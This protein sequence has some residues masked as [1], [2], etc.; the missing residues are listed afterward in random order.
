MIRYACLAVS[1]WTFAVRAEGV[2]VWQYSD[3]VD[4]VLSAEPLP[5]GNYLIANSNAFYELVPSP[6]SG[7][8]QINRLEDN[9]TT[10]FRLENGNTLAAYTFPDQRVQ[11]VTPAN[12]IAWEW[13]GGVPACNDSTPGNIVQLSQLS[14]GDVL[15]S[16]EN[17]H[18]VMR[19]TRA[20]T[21]AWQFGRGDCLTDTV[22]N[23]GLFKPNGV[24]EHPTNGNLLIAEQRMVFEITPV[25]ATG[26]TMVR[27]YGDG[28]NVGAADNQVAGATDVAVLP[29]GHWMIVDSKNRRLV[30]VIPSDGTTTGSVVWQYGVT[31]VPSAAPNFLHTPTTVRLLPNG[32]FLVIDTGVPNVME[33]SRLFLDVAPSP[34]LEVGQCSSALGVQVRDSASGAQVAPFDV[35]V[36]LSPSDPALELFTDASCS[37]PLTAPV[38]FTAGVGSTTLY[39]KASAEGAFA[40]NASASGYVTDQQSISAALTPPPGPGGG[41]GGPTG[42]LGDALNSRDL[43]VGCACQSIPASALSFWSIP[44]LLAAS[45]RRRRR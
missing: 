31:G 18:R 15:L 43:S 16:D 45:R 25:G 17:E 37:T 13:G 1:L 8:T 21:K 39:A 14:N 30:E 22:P 7:G 10:A 28:I 35:D 4:A 3:P 20:G 32:N 42:T 2:V 12:T 36:T 34:T 24:H 26:G 9:W 11:E 6:G 38:S 23:G 33:I 44:L 27:W 41:T 29:N 40:I 5:N 19:I